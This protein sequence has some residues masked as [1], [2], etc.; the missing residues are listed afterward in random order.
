MSAHDDKTFQFKR[1]LPRPSPA[2][3]SHSRDPT[4][5][6][7][8]SLEENG[9]L[10]KLEDQC[11]STV[12]T[13]QSPL[14]APGDG[15]PSRG[16]CADSIGQRT[17]GTL[18]CRDHRCGRARIVALCRALQTEGI[19]RDYSHSW[20]LRGPQHRSGRRFRH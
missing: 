9:P 14:T 17:A 13:Q 16:S 18:I 8:S 5:E 7:F 4:Q 12:S 10:E 6:N 2:S 1:S 19:I 11:Q 15:A 20:R 3:R